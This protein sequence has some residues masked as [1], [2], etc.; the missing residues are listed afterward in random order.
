[1]ST[2]PAVRVKMAG[3][4]TV[5]VV[6]QLLHVCQVKQGL[7]MQP[8]VVDRGLMGPAEVGKLLPLLLL[9]LLLH[10]YCHYIHVHFGFLDI[11]HTVEMIKIFDILAMSPFSIGNYNM[12]IKK[13]PKKQCKVLIVKC[14][15]DCCMVYTFYPKRY[16]THQG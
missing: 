8:Q 13:K 9:P 6:L 2:L 5:A 16:G 3:V 14:N 15:T 7:G 4:V 11:S 12:E 10:D 1:M